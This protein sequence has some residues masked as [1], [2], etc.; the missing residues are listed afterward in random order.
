MT[1]QDREQTAKIVE[2]MKSAAPAAKKPRPRRKPLV[3][4]PGVIYVKGN[5]NVV[6]GGA[7]SQVTNVHHH[8]PAR[9][10]VVVKTGDGTVDARQKAE[11]QRLLR[12][13]VDAYNA[14][15]VRKLTW[16]AAWGGFN[17]AM[18]VSGYGE[19]RPEQFDAACAWLQ[20]QAA[21]VTGANSA[22]KKLPSWRTKRYAAIKARCVNQLGDEFAYV[23][24][25]IK[26]FAKTSLTELTDAELEQTYRYVMGKSP[27]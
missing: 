13:W 24:Y 7:V 17:K 15:K 26:H 1:D 22:P 5:G 10:K 16:A 9:P 27:G 14:V 8:Q 20:R 23:A 19:L 12:A 25:T 6:A 11:L 3:K 21:I 4:E 2:L 18:R